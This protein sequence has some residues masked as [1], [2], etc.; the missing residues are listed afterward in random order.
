MVI[1]SF[2][3]FQGINYAPVNKITEY[4]TKIVVSLN[5]HYTIPGVYLLNFPVAYYIVKIKKTTKPITFE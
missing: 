1:A 3:R 4:N 2:D 5:Y